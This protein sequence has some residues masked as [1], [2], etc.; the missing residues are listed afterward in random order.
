M[1]TTGELVIMIHF[2]CSPYLTSQK[3]SGKSNTLRRLRNQIHR[4]GLVC[5][6]LT[7]IATVGCGVTSPTTAITSIA[8]AS[9]VA[10]GSGFTMTISG[11]K[12]SSMSLVLLNGQARATTF[13]SDT[14]LK[15]AIFASDIGEPGTPSLV[16]AEPNS[17]APAPVSNSVTLKV[18]HRSD[19][20]PSIASVSPNAGPTAG[21][22]AVAIAG[23]KFH[24]EATVSFGSSAASSI[25]VSSST[26]IRVV[27][28]AHIAGNAA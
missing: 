6:S 28:P 10:G 23:S 15:A 25:T 22:T 24:N 3:H 12:F 20:S 16:V 8:P 2:G 17:L 14:Q 9:V 21:G 1:P 26:Q 4:F 11:S 27:T 19:P 13:V 5:L 7:A 18:K